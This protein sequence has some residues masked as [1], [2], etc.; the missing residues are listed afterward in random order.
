MEIGNL[1]SGTE[2]NEQ[3]KGSRLA[4]VGSITIGCISPKAR[5]L[6]DL[7]MQEWEATGVQTQVFSTY[8]FT[9]WL[10]R[11]SGLVEPSEKALEAMNDGY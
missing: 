10:V 11:W 6:L 5:G 9:Y 3:M 2:K 4:Q 8:G 1:Q 7:V